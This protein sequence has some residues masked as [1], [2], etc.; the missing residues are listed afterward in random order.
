MVNLFITKQHVSEASIILVREYLR[1]TLLL[2]TEICQKL[3]VAT[4]NFVC[5]TLFGFVIVPSIK[6]HKTT[7]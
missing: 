7:F 5:A 4:G 2:I 1:E 6:T 3:A